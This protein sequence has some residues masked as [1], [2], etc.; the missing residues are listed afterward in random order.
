[1]K[2][3]L[4]L[5]DRLWLNHEY[6]LGIWL[7]SLLLSTVDVLCFPN[8]CKYFYPKIH[9]CIL[10]SKVVKL[11]LWKPCKKQLKFHKPVQQEI[12]LCEPG[13]GDDDVWRSTSTST[14]CYLSKP[15]RWRV[16]VPQWISSLTLLCNELPHL[17]V[18][19]RNERTRHFWSVTQSQCL[20][21]LRLLAACF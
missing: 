17:W 2:T 10:G 15:V 3:T 5:A 21:S 6:S 19:K 18:L 12:W 1:M 13:W 20:Y 8:H 9:F 14:L 16:F 7:V 4:S 11:Q